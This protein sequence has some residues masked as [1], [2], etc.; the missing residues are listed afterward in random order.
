[1]AEQYITETL[2][3]MNPDTLTYV[4][5]NLRNFARM[6]DETLTAQLAEADLKLSMC[7]PAEAEFHQA[8][9][10]LTA[11]LADLQATF[12]LRWKADTRAI[13]Q[14][15]AAHPDKP[16]VWPDH[17]DL[18]LWLTAQLEQANELLETQ[19]NECATAWSLL[20]QERANN[21]TLRDSNTILRSTR[22]T[23]HDQVAAERE[24]LRGLLDGLVA[25]HLNVCVGSPAAGK[26]AWLSR[27][28]AASILTDAALPSEEVPE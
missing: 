26:V 24:R 4:A 3:R 12:D 7:G 10:S 15:Q 8:T 11:Q 20:E 5:G 16:L 2:R 23:L 13:K 9:A 14:W 19:V 27:F 6:V 17:V 22:D 1:M 18:V 25:G 21:T 28:E